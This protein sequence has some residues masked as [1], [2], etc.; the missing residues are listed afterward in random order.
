MLLAA[1]SHRQKV[2]FWR[3]FGF[4]PL[5]VVFAKFIAGA[6]S[7]GGGCSLGREGPTVHIAGAL[8]SNIAGWLGVAKQGR[9]PALVTLHDVLRLQQQQSDAV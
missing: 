6:I 5:R 9:R 3:D 1:V 4:M 2:A 8:A 7:I